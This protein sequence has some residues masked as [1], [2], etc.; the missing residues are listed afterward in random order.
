MDKIYTLITHPTEDTAFTATHSNKLKLLYESA[1]KIAKGYGFK[2][3]IKDFSSNT[4]DLIAN[5]KK[6]TKYYDEIFSAIADHAYQLTSKRNREYDFFPLIELIEIN[7]KTFKQ[8][9]ISTY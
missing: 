8:K 2:G 9:K 6:A 3:E 1:T 4:I 7:T 5:N